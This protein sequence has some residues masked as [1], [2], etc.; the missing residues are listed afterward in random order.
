MAT[1]TR[2]RTF[3]LGAAVAA[4]LAPLAL[5]VSS[6]GPA[7][8]AVGPRPHEVYMYKVERHVDLSGEF[9]DNAAHEDLSCNDGDYALDG[10]WRVD[11]VDQADPQLGTYGDERDVVFY[12]SYSDLTDKSEWHFRFENLADGNAQVKLFLTCIRKQTEENAGHRHGIDLMD[13]VVDVTHHG[14]AGGDYHWNLPSLCPSGYYAVAPGFNFPNDDKNHIFRSWPSDDFRGWQ[15]AFVIDDSAHPGAVDVDVAVRCLSTRLLAGGPNPVHTH[16][17]PMTWRPNGYSGYLDP[18]N[19]VG[20]QE[21]RINCDDG[22]NG[23]SFQDYKAMVGSF[24][25]ADPHHAWY[26]GMDPRP[27]QRSYQFWWDGAG[28][29]STYMGALC[30]KSRTGKQLKP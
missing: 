29:N 5:V 7:S 11:H 19:V 6:A 15:W 12:A 22:F 13:P 2:S 20:R 18:L 30:V 1:R 28:S 9:P 23:A 26:L 27:K 10:M 4:L 16:Q 8:S 17:L 24:W 25:I 21:R 3:L 14:L